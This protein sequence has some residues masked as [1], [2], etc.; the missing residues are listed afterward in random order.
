MRSRWAVVFGVAVVCQPLT[1]A[2]AF[3][4]A[5][6]TGNAFGRYGSGNTTFGEVSVAGLPLAN[7]DTTSAQ[8]VSTTFLTVGGVGETLL[9]GNAIGGACGWLGASNIPVEQ[10]NFFL[11]A[12]GGVIYIDSI[13]VTSSTLS[14]GTPVQIMYS[15]YTAHTLTV[16]HSVLNPGSQSNHALGLCSVQINVTGP[17]GSMFLAANDNKAFK[18]TLDGSDLAIGLMAPPFQTSFTLDAAVGDAI[19]FVLF[20]DADADGDVGPTGPL[21]DM[22]GAGSASVA[23]ALA[24]GASVVSPNAALGEAEVTLTSDAYP[25]GFPAASLATAAAA[26]AGLPDSIIFSCANIHRF[27]AKCTN[28]GRIKALVRMTDNSLD[29]QT[30]TI[31]VDGTPFVRTI[32]NGAAKLNTPATPGPHTVTLDD[33]PGCAAPVEVTCP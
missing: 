20:A 23:V 25:G 17:G 27:R 31:S 8:Q 5:A 28:T 26:E 9:S 22:N 24:F 29:G 32:V 19:M 10:T 11:V 3:G 1:S 6:I 18:D 30:V 16:T 2:Y 15:F 33:P 14:I 4:G 7:D 21:S 13:N 12:G